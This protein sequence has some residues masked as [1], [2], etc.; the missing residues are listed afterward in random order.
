MEYRIEPS[1]W[2]PGKLNVFQRDTHGTHGGWTRIGRV[3]SPADAAALVRS[4]DWGLSGL[5][6]FATWA[7][8]S[9]E[10]AED[11]VLVALVEAGEHL[12]DGEP[13]E[14]FRARCAEIE[15]H[16][17]TYFGGVRDLEVYDTQGSA[18]R[19]DEYDGSESV[20]TA[21]DFW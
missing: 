11:P 17:K 21:S 7:T 8:K 4:R 10:L 20:R 19:I 14:A 3:E 2:H 9:K 13:S 15:G 18:Y 16:A 6:G 12:T 5:I 1:Y